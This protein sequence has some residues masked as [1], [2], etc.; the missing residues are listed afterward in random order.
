MLLVN[1]AFDDLQDALHAAIHAAKFSEGLT[2]TGCAIQLVVDKLLPKMR[3]GIP[4]LVVLITDGKNNGL[5][6]PVIPADLLKSR[7]V[8]IFTVGITSSIDK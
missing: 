1:R 5:E 8:R 7:G 4:K 6:N 2:F 3:R